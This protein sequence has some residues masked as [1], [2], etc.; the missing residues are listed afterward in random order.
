MTRQWRKIS[1]VPHLIASA[2]A[3]LAADDLL[4]QT[5]AA[6]SFRDGTRVA[7][8]RPELVGAMCGG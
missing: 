6:G 2:L 3:A 8:S 7:A 4:A 5:L 1:H